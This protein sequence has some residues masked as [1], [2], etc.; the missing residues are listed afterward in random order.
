MSASRHTRQMR[1]AEV[2]AQGQARL[3]EGEGCV[4]S[5][6]LAGAIAARYTAG[7]GFGALRVR[8]ALALEAARAIDGRVRVVVDEALTPFEAP[9][10]LGLAEPA[11]RQVAAGAYEA[12][13]AIRRALGS[14]FA[15]RP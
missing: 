9:A 4:S 10:W 13:E 11:A 3:C 5:D 2:G 6:G 12:L 14:S 7:A 15:G 1:L 8:S